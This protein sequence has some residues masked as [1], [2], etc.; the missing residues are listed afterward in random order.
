MAPSVVSP[1]PEARE[2]VRVLYQFQPL[3]EKGSF[4]PASNWQTLLTESPVRGT[5][6]IFV[7]LFSHFLLGRHQLSSP[8]P[9]L[10]PTSALSLTRGPAS[11]RTLHTCL[12]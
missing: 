1:I 4:P 8:A 7:C 6:E 2:Q 9:T 10:L 5:Q 12:A 11:S 3:G